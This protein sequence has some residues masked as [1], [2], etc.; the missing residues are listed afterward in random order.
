MRSVAREHRAICYLASMDWRNEK[1]WP[2]AH[3]PAPS[4]PYGFINSINWMITSFPYTNLCNN[5]QL[6]CHRSVYSDDAAHFFYYYCGFLRR[7]RC[8]HISRVCFTIFAF[9]FLHSFDSGETALFVCECA[10][11]SQRNSYHILICLQLFFACA[12]F[13]HHFDVSI[14]QIVSVCI[15]LIIISCVRAPRSGIHIA[16]NMTL[17]VRALRIVHLLLVIHFS[18]AVF[19]RISKLHRTRRPQGER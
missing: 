9:H 10:R 6:M 8:Q 2:R 11:S 15:A 4:R 1:N 13:L 19:L 14:A 12:L 17:C 18:S 16:K 7:R 5:I 3:N